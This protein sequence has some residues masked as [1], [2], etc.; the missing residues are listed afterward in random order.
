MPLT[1]VL[2]HQAVLAVRHLISTGVQPQNIQVVGD[3]AGANLALALMSHLLHPVPEIPQLFLSSPLRGVYLM[4]PWVALG[5]PYTGS[6][7][8]N[9]PNDIIGPGCIENWGGLVLASIKDKPSMKPYVERILMSGG[10]AEV[11]SD[12]ILRF[13]DQIAPHHSS[14]SFVME[15]YGVHNDH[16]FDFLLRAKPGKGELTPVIVAWLAEGFE[17]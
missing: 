7:I 9:D 1:H 6:I 3:S 14:L 16:Y 17:S 11:L 2:L 8:T 13:A 12:S 10:D 4:S 5:G 15:S